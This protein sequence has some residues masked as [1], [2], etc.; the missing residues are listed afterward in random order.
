MRAP[1]LAIALL[2]AYTALATPTLALAE[3][4]TVAIDHS[5]RLNV[6]GS[7]A[8][9]VNSHTLFVSGRGYGQT[10]VLVL[11]S[12]GRTVY[13]GE[14]LVGNTDGGRVSVYRGATRTDMACAPGCA[15]AFRSATKGTGNGSE[16]GAVT[17]GA[18]AASPFAGA[19]ANLVSPPA[20]HA[21][22]GQ[23]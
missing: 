10:D 16:G 19:L 14:V 8:S 15:V 22:T 4:L 7:A 1:A 3:T 2:V 17:A 13:A 9:V 23:P 20:N 18:G 6:A 11:D 5:T 21:P 12:L